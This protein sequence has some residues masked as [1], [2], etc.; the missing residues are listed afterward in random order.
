MRILT[1]RWVF[2]LA[3]ATLL[4]ACAS[5]DTRAR[6][7]ARDNIEQTLAAA[8]QPAPATPPAAVTNALLPELGVAL[9]GDAE[10][11][12]D[13]VVNDAEA[14]S[15]FMGLARGTP[16]NMVL[17]PDVKGRITLNMQAVSIPETLD[18]VSRLYGYGIRR[19]GDTFMVLPA[20]I[21]TRVFHVD[22]LN[23]IREGTSRT[24]VSSGQATQMPLQTQYAGVFG[25]GAASSGAAGGEQ[26]ENRAS[27]S[28][29]TQSSS[30]FWLELDTTLRM[31]VPDGEGRNVVINDATG[32]I[33]VRAMPGELR[34]VEDYLASLQTS[35][36][37]QVV[38][39]AKFI[40]VE[41]KDGFQTGINWWALAQ[42]ASST[43]GGGMI[44]SGSLF[45][46]G[47][48]PSNTVTIQPGN[49]VTGFD[50]T[51]FGGVF[52]LS[53]D[54]GDFNAFV[55]LL[56]TQGDTHVLSAPRVTALNNQKAVI[57]VGSDEFF[58]TGLNSNTVAGTATNTNQNIQLT[59]FFSGIALDVTPQISADGEVLLHIH[60]SISEV[61]D[62]IKE[63]QFGGQTQRIPLAFSTV[64]EADTLVRA[65]S[66]Q[67]IVIGGLMKTSTE[68]QVAKVPVL[69]DIP[70]LGELFTQRKQV[71]IKSELVILLKPIVV[72]S[73][74]D[75]RELVR[76]PQTR[77]F[78]QDGEAQ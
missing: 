49:P 26:R 65:E 3:A 5:S 24:R 29:E 20:T 36:Q 7:D 58:V 68:D 37:R 38:L 77:L 45:E 22:Y 52:A 13:V 64:R 57:K 78:G 6:L 62:Q 18:V 70:V 2:L 51:T 32:V 74:A 48:N 28:I 21:Q 54:N 42:N 1:T 34:S 41:L 10:P 44:N 67:I 12:F 71:Q 66:G 63:I 14:R 69:G 61:R 43:I 76:E 46:D 8:S 4:A 16:Y 17:H 73:G 39:E 27:T 15:F 55:E 56:Q 19:T 30:D 31:L 50:T 23:L 25:G 11:R 72:N 40:E 33:M 35:A 47:A 75:W 59:P 60:P 9:P 53:Y